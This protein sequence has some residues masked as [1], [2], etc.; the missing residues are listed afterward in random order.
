MRAITLGHYLPGDSLLHKLDPRIKLLCLLVLIVTLFLVRT[1][2]GFILFGAFI[3]IIFLIAKLPWRYFLRGLRP[4]LYI[5]LFTL[6]LH[7]LFTKGGKVYWR[8]GPLSVEEAGIYMGTFMTLRLILLVVTTL[9][10]TLTTS[11]I[12][13]ADGI[14]FMLRPFRR[15]GIPGHEIAMMMTIALR[16][17]PTLMEESDKIRKAQIARGADFETGNIFRRARNLVP[18]LVPLFVSAFRRADELAIAMEARCYQGGKGR[19]KMRE[20]HTKP[21]D[22]FGLFTSF[23]M[24]L[25]ILLGRV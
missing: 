5:I 19:T 4:V 3:F 8:L 12:S 25:V 18:L 9:L 24:M 7:F 17:I 23:G 21:L 13:F 16:F 1:F 14:E 20:L 22:Y 10:I 11:P 15:L 6:I 2:W